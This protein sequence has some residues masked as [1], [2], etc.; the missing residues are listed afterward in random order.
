MYDIE[1]GVVGRGGGSSLMVPYEV[2]EDGRMGS[3][4]NPGGGGGW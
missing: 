4:C 2:R 3:E 1:V